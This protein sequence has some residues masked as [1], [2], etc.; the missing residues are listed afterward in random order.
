MKFENYQ[1]I[2]NKFRKNYKEI[3]RMQNILNHF[4]RFLDFCE[5]TVQTLRTNASLPPISLSFAEFFKQSPQKFPEANAEKSLKSQ[6]FVMEFAF[7]EKKS[8]NSSFLMEQWIFTVHADKLPRNA[9]KI[10]RTE[11]EL[12]QSLRSFA[13][14]VANLCVNLPLYREFLRPDAK[15]SKQLGYDF[16][17]QGKSTR[18]LAKISNFQGWDS[19]KWSRFYAKFPESEDFCF[20][21]ICEQIAYKF[22]FRVN[23]F[24]NVF[25]L[26]KVVEPA[27]KFRERCVSDNGFSQRNCEGSEEKCEAVAWNGGERRSS[28]EESFDVKGNREKSK[29][30]H[31]FFGG[32]VGFY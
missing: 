27:R 29:E 3:G 23:F 4:S 32:F 31:R 14:T 11:D 16:E 20:F 10:V 28:L 9:S 6:L 30:F 15:Y 7:K 22:S 17:L 25:H 1:E 19:E 5:E 21:V 18:E 26:Y 13:K 24:K 2:T 8:A 12:A